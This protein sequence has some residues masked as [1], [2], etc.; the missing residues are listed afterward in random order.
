M[1]TRIRFSLAI[2]D[3]VA[4]TDNVIMT[5]NQF[6]CTETHCT[7]CPLAIADYTDN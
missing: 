3:T 6:E 5:L 7:M 4:I 2:W 1:R